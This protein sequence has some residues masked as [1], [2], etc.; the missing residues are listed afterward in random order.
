MTASAAA[1]LKSGEIQVSY[2]EADDAKTFAGNPQFRIVEGDSYVVGSK[3]K[4][5][6]TRRE[7]SV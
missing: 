2:V 7:V 3:R 4:P 1:A 5:L 6:T